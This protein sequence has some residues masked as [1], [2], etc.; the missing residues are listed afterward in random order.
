MLV[1]L[2]IVPFLAGT[3]TVAADDGQ[4]GEN[5][6]VGVPSDRAPVFYIDAE[7]GENAGIGIDL[8]QEAAENAGIS[9]TFKTIEEENL[10][11]ALDNDS[12]D[13]IM[14]LG[15]DIVSASGK[16]S[17]VTAN[18]TETPF[19]L[20]TRKKTKL[21]PMNDLRVGMLTSMKGGAE[22]VHELYP[23]M[24]IT[25]FE[26]MP[27]CVSA[28]RAGK[29]DAL[30]HNSYVWSYVLQ[31]PSYE[32]LSVQPSAMFSMDFRAGAL[33]TP[34]NKVLIERLN[35]GIDE[36]T[37]TKRQA[38]VLDHTTRKL[39]KYDLDDYVYL[40]GAFIVLCGLLFAALIMVVILKQ[41]TIRLEQ[42]EKM[43]RM[44]DH[45]LL[46]G[47]LSL[48][49]FRKLV[50]ELL[51]KHPDIPY[52]MSYN[53]IKD[54]KYINDS[55]G[56]AAGDELLKFWVE[57]TY[58]M[59]TDVEAMGRIE[60]DHFAVLRRIGGDEKMQRDDKVV[61][62]PLRNFF[63][64]QGKEMQVR[65]CSGVYVLTEKDY[66]DIDVDRMLDFARVAE[67]RLR[68]TKKDGF[69]FYNPAQ[70]EKGRRTA[71]IVSRFPIA[72]DS[73]EISVWYQPQVN[74][75]TGDIIGAEALC[76]WNH[77]KL[78]W[79]SP[80][81]YV[82]VLENVGQI[83][84]LDCF[85]W[86]TV[87]A[88]LSRWKKGGKRHRV[89]VNL[90]REDIEANG[91]IADHFNELIKKYGIDAD[92][93]A[94]EITESAY[95][96]ETDSLI[97]T[98]EKLREYG[99]KVEM[100]DFGSGYSSLNMLKKV[101]VDRIKLDLHF[102]DKSGNPEMGKTII[103]HIIQMVHE[104]GMGIV[105]EGVETEKQALFLKDLDCAVMQGFFFYKPMPVEEFEKLDI[106]IK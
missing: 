46:T 100:D 72:L 77:S 19:T 65:I 64:D 66:Q 14:P 92:Q 9:V 7:T 93:I 91:E 48:N 12:Y 16:S 32:N 29:V 30:L 85:V 38:I 75:V 96:E 102:Q 44:I 33:D 103:K 61:F 58:E 23:G 41:H 54:F 83:Y 105:A 47:S 63:I 8:M 39:Y 3:Q 4:R 94:V 45:D 31:K 52:L 13:I 101:P 1:T 17:I 21:P 79:V 80:S 88:D 11:A 50:E 42:D 51:R 56:R 35:K 87:C 86:E 10:K 53:N 98:T 55:F 69:E 89:S 22:I 36:I 43:R 62:T 84:E 37:D 106:K 97:Q 70:W 68:D 25:M 24:N 27:E 34:E 18:L 26:T 95:V 71:D 73:G 82:P 60:N 104:L 76:R 6:T 28:L 40:H 2:F 20:V 59:L 49:G 15:G 78:G 90:S 81:E 99:F 5:I 57:K 74:Y 67:N